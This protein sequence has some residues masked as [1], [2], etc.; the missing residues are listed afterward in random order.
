MYLSAGDILMNY[1]TINHYVE[2]V[3]TKS[4]LDWS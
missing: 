1:P 3:D 4:E 2:E